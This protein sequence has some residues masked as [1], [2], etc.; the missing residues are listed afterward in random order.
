MQLPKRDSR[1][2]AQARARLCLFLSGQVKRVLCNPLKILRLVQ[3][4]G[5]CGILGMQVEEPSLPIAIFEEGVKG[6]R[7]LNSTWVENLI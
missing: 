7:G 5:Y 6:A 4:A 1:G 2:L 3:T